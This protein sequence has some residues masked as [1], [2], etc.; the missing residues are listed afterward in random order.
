MSGKLATAFV[1]H[2]S[3]LTIGLASC[4]FLGCAGESRDAKSATSETTSARASGDANRALVKKYMDDVWIRKDPD[5]VAKY[6]A[7][8]LV[9]HAAIPSAQGA[10]GM[11]NIVRKVQKAFPDLK[12]TVEAIAADED[13]V[14]A[15]VTYEGTH[16]EALEFAKPIPASNNHVRFEQVHTYR[17]KDGRIVETWM[18]MDR[19][20]VLT[21]LGQI[22]KPAP[23]P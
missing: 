18:L 17:V 9:N 19:L 7:A 1:R 4:G 14:I 2:A 11:S 20:D 8:D 6:T 23:A 10:A 13:V 5:A 22:P 16:K 3:L 12:T 15:R 21:Q